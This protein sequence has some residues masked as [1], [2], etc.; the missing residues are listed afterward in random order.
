MTTDTPTFTSKA[1]SFYVAYAPEAG[2]WSYGSCFEEAVNSLAEELRSL[3]GK[4]D[5]ELATKENRHAVN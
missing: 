3:E 4:P 5:E 2:I 1:Q